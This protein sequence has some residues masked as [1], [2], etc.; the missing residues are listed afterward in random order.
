MGDDVHVL[1]PALDHERFSQ[2]LNRG[3][4]SADRVHLVKPPDDHPFP[5]RASEM[6]AESLQQFDIPVNPKVVKPTPYPNAVHELY[7]LIRA[8]AAPGH[9]VY[10]NVSGGPHQLCNAAS[11]AASYVVSDVIY[12]PDI[13]STAAIDDV[14]SKIHFY[15]TEPEKHYFNNLVNAYDEIEAA[16]QPERVETLQKN[17]NELAERVQRDRDTV[18]GFNMLL[19]ADLD[20]V[21]DRFGSSENPDLDESFELLRKLVEGITITVEAMSELEQNKDSIEDT[22]GMF[23]FAEPVQGVFDLMGDIK[24][25]DEP[26]ESTDLFN[27]FENRLETINQIVSDAQALESS[28]PE[29]LTKFAEIENKGV[30]QG[31]QEFD[32]ITS[33]NPPAYYLDQPGSLEFDLRPTERALL[34]TL[35]D[36]ES[37]DSVQQFTYQVFR[38]A[39][40]NAPAT[41]VNLPDTSDEQTFWGASEP[42]EDTSDLADAIQSTVQYNL[43]QLDDKGFV[44]RVKGEGRKKEMK[45]TRA[46]E[47]YIHTIEFDEYWLGHAFEDLVESIKATRNT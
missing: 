27:Y 23:G 13:D 5:T 43:Q 29:S 45:F 20:A 35:W 39:V 18:R 2:P 41:E 3:K 36:V 12:G 8:E 22:F 34:Y 17:V 44:K 47:I 1:T 33:P 7:D 31:V 10:I 6:L 42:D 19:S 24:D 30:A 38:R 28:P 37:A 46:G 4:L 21:A 32:E 26:I 9:D 40:L 25:E 14:R 11:T 15:S 16:L